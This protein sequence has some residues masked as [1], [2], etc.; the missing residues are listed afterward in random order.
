MTTNSEETNAPV[1]AGWRS[2]F[3]TVRAIDGAREWQRLLRKPPGRSGTARLES[4]AYLAEWQPTL[5]A[6]LNG[7]ELPAGSAPIPLW[8]S[9]QVKLQ[10]E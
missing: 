4:D 8:V 5:E 3:T 6:I 10:K 7:N 2:E 9:W 1:S